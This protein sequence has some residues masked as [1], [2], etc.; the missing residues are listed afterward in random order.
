MEDKDVLE[1]KPMYCSNCH[2]LI[3]DE[4]YFSCLDNYL[5]VNYF[6]TEE[7][8]I[9]C[10]KDCFCEALTLTEIEDD[11]ELTQEEMDFGKAIMGKQV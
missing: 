10:S 6:D 7:E 3:T 1:V 8:N 4:T 11:I 9:F 2:E 5:Q